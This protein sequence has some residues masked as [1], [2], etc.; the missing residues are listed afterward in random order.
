LSFARRVDG[1]VCT[2]GDSVKLVLLRVDDARRGVIGAHYE[3]TRDVDGDSL[4][5]AIFF[6]ADAAE[7][8]LGDVLSC[9]SL[10]LDSRQLAKLLA[11]SIKLPRLERVVGRA[12]HD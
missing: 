11:L 8:L 2:H 7:E 5:R 4:K 1:L 12:R 3:V 10:L 9:S 6:E